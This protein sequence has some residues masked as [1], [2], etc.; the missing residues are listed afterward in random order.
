MPNMVH[1]EIDRE[2][3]KKLK[4]YEQIVDLNEDESLKHD[5]AIEKL[6]DNSDYSDKI[7]SLVEEE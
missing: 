1:I 3:W 7:K 6:I 5:E 4:A 2:I